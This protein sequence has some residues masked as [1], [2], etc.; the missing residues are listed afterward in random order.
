MYPIILNKS[1]K[2]ELKNYFEEMEIKKIIIKTKMEYKYM[3]RNYPKIEIRNNTFENVY[4]NTYFINL[5]ANIGKKISEDS[6]SKIR[7]NII[8]NCKTLNIKKRITNYLEK[9]Y[10]KFKNKG[11]AT[12]T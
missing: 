1:V 9:I 7:E 12:S 6:Y 10:K 2:N 5:Y 4:I 3:V 11:R 8:G